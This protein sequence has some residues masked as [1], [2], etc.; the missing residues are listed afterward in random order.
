MPWRRQGKHQLFVYLCPCLDRYLMLVNLLHI[1]LS[2]FV[3]IHTDF[4]QAG[5]GNSNNYRL[6]CV[7]VFL[8]SL[9]LM[10]VMILICNL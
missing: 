6:F 9:I 7:Q 2:D 5:S 3:G 10:G 4:H 8:V 1:Q